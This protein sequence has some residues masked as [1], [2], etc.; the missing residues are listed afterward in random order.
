MTGFLATAGEVVAVTAPPGPPRLVEQAAGERLAATAP[1]PP[2]VVLDLQADGRPFDRA[3]L[4][5][6]TRGA[7][8]GGGRVLLLD[9]CSSGFDL[10]VTA[11]EPGRHCS[12]CRR[13][14]GRRPDPGGEPRPPGRFRLL[15]G[16]TLVHYPV[17]W[18]SG[19][20]GRVPLHA[21]L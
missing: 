4:R 5:P 8:A 17:L 12:R 9:A 2:T 3:G 15:A 6:L 14:T 20:R 19:W 21:A 18:R 1:A 11:G 7:Y 10:L 13:V 16:Q